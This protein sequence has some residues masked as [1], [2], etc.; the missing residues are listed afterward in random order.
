MTRLEAFCWLDRRWT[1]R[2]HPLTDTQEHLREKLEFR[3]F[4]ECSDVIN[5]LRDNECVADW[6]GMHG[7]GEL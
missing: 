2:P 5:R 1:G 4:E 3:A 6:D 7:G